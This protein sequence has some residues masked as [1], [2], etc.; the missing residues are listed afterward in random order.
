MTIILI[1]IVII[2]FCFAILVQAISPVESELSLFELN[3]RSEQGDRVAKKQLERETLLDS[4]FSL[5]DFVSL[6]LFVASIILSIV[7]FGWVYGLILTLILIILYKK[8]IYLSIFSKLA[9]KIYEKFEKKLL[10]F[11]KKH[12]NLLLFIIS[13]IK[14]DRKFSLG[15]SV[16]LQNMI[17]SSVGVLSEDEKAL[18]VNGLKFNQQKVRS[19]MTPRESI[20]TVARKEFL[21]PLALDELH[22]TGHTKLPVINDDIDHIIGILHLDS[23]F[24]LDDKK[25]VTAEKAMEQ[26][27]FY[28]RDNHTL[29]QALTEFIST[30]HYLLVVINKARE[31]VGILTLSDVVKALVGHDVKDEF[32]FYDNSR[33]VASHKKV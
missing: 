29:S 16:E 18:I 10:N 24:T 26:R 23:L 22:R 2:I 4:V 21:G 32:D 1:L 5:R 13:P 3:H 17:D 8:A 28:I 15:S 25:S 6:I 9:N 19:I 11:I 14:R 12:R 27:V 31:T 7:F 33:I 30:R 20:A